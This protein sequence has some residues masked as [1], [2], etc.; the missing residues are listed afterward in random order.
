MRAASNTYRA[1][2][3]DS[4]LRKLVQKQLLSALSTKYGAVLGVVGLLWTINTLASLF[5]WVFASAP[6]PVCLN[7]SRR[8]FHDNLAGRQFEER[9]CLPVIDVVY[10]WVNGS[11]PWLQ[12][13]VCVCVCVCMC[14]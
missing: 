8:D 3:A 12:V 4:P 14:V 10:T 13:C 5:L 11:D 2:R 7:C 1:S 9:Q 6:A